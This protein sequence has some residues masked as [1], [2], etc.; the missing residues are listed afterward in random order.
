MGTQ[1]WKDSPCLWNE[2]IKVVKMS[3]LHKVIYRFSVILI[4]IQMTF[5]ID[6]Y[7]EFQKQPWLE[8]KKTGDILISDFKN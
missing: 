5:I 3:I 7:L 4:K 6:I 2:R 1:K 8:K